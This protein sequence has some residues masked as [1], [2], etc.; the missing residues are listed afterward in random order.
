MANLSTSIHTEN[1]V[2]FG[3]DLCTNSDSMLCIPFKKARNA[4]K[5]REII[6]C[7]YLIYLGYVSELSDAFIFPN[8]MPQ[9]ALVCKYGMS[10]NLYDRLCQHNLDYGRM[11]NRE[12]QLMFYTS[13][14]KE[15]IRHSESLLQ[16]HFC[17]NGMRQI[18]KDIN[19]KT[20]KELIVFKKTQS[21]ID[22]IIKLFLETA[23]KPKPIRL[24]RSLSERKFKITGKHKKYYCGCGR[25]YVQKSGLTRHR[26]KTGCDESLHSNNPLEPVDLFSLLKQKDTEITNLRHQLDNDQKQLQNKNEQLKQKDEQLKQKDEEIQY[27]RKE[28]SIM[29]RASSRSNVDRQY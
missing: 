14:S 18:L 13:M 24:N 2:S 20:R 5:K 26:V 19:G 22:S 1:S 10:E 16:Q 15:N 27:L 4:L 9:D 7:T 21:N 29:I 28:L 25:S 8:D 3:T 6:S 12:V 11:T 23:D 17:D